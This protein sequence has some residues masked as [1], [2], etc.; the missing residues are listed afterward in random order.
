MNRLESIFGQFRRD[1]IRLTPIRKAVVS[2]LAKSKKPI[3]VEGVGNHLGRLGL[4][5]NKVTLY[6]E[7]DF[8]VRKGWVTALDLGGGRQCYEWASGHHHHL[9]CRKCNR[10]EELEVH[11]LEPAFAKFE[12]RLGRKSGFSDLSHSL[13]FYGICKRCR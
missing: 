5:P 11:E 7:V 13:E 2:V 4:S 3:C 9:V 1:G 10:I 6:R 8:L 12:K